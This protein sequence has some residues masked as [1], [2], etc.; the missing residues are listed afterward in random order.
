MKSCLCAR[1]NKIFKIKVRPSTS[2]AITISSYL[3]ASS[4]TTTLCFPGGSVTF[5]WANILILFLTTSIPLYKKMRAITNMRNA[6]SNT[7]TS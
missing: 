7:E 3:S 2:K 4:R 5:F 6:G 1:A